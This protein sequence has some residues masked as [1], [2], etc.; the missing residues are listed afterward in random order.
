MASW[1]AK[2]AN[3]DEDISLVER[4]RKGDRVAF[5]RLYRRH[6]DLPGAIPGVGWSDHGSFWQSGYPAVMI[7]DTAPFRY[8]HYHAT[9]DTPE[10]I[11]YERLARVVSGLAAVTVDLAEAGP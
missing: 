2:S 7:T 9:T 3:H 8:P 11:D 10:R 6:R 4:A 1:E 5:E